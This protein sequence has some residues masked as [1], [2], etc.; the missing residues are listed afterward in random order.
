[1]KNKTIKKQVVF[2]IFL[3]YILYCSGPA[4]TLPISMGIKVGHGLVFSAALSLEVTTKLTT[5]ILIWFVRML[6]SMIM[7]VCVR[8]VFIVTTK[9]KAMRNNHHDEQDDQETS[10]LFYIF[11]LY[12]ML[13]T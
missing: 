5:S 12:I 9:C 2:V 4:S 13:K 1:M 7:Y 3:Y 8:C 10:S 11:I 6:Q